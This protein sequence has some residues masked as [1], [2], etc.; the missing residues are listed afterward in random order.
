MRRTKDDERELLWPAA[1]AAAR[2]VMKSHGVG[3]FSPSLCPSLPPASPPSR[4]RGSRASKAVVWAHAK[5]FSACLP[6]CLFPPS[7]PG[8]GRG[9]ASPLSFPPPPRM[10][11]TRDTGYYHSSSCGSR[12]CGKGIVCRTE[13]RKERAKERTNEQTYDL[14]FCW[15]RGQWRRKMRERERE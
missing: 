4:A 7:L 15:Q 2:A 14:S 1:A 10:P 13:G 5:C 8:R 11:A 3:S 9:P 12:C 6:A